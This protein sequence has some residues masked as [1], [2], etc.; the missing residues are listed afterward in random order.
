MTT[1]PATCTP[2][3]CHLALDVR[4]DGA[5]TTVRLDG[6]LELTT[7]ELLLDV[8]DGVLRQ[9][10]ATPAAPARVVL[11]A[12]DLSFCDVTGLNA[13]LE[14]QRRA[15]RCGGHLHLR[16]VRPFLRHVIAAAG[17]DCLLDGARRTP[18]GT[19]DGTG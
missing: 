13:L 15:D 4:A 8:V 10:T 12:R 3:T 9:A 7:A 17:A 14:V 19:A 5:A 2:A 1:H 18:R 6:E 11:D 16:T